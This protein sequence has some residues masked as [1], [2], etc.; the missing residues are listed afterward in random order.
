MNFTKQESA[1]II[2]SKTL[3]LTTERPTSHHRTL[4]FKFRTW[5]AKL[6]M[7]ERKKDSKKTS[8]DF[9]ILL[10]RKDREWFRSDGAFSTCRGVHFE[11]VCQVLWRGKIRYVCVYLL[12][13]CGRWSVPGFP[14]LSDNFVSWGLELKE[15]QQNIYAPDG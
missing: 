3:Y 13:K 4:T 7:W 5:W 6:T 10:L 12:H 2:H 14:R 15:L 11:S 9:F 8:V 1:L